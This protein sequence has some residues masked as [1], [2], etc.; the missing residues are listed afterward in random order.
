MRRSGALRL[1][2]LL[3]ALRTILPATD[4]PIHKG[5]PYFTG[6]NDELIVKDH[7]LKWFFRAGNTVAFPT[8]S[9]GLVFFSDADKVVY[10]LDAETGAPVWRLDLRTLS[11]Q[12]GSGTAVAG[13][14]KA[15]LIQGERL[16]LS[17]A[18]ILYCLDKRRGG[19]LW[20]RAGLQEGDAKRFVV[21]GIYA[22][23]LLEGQRLIYGT[24]KN[25]MAR[26]PQNGHLAWSNGDPATFGGFP[27]FYDGLVITQSRDFAK[28]RYSLVCLNATNGRTLWE[29][30]LENP[31]QILYP[32]VWKDRVYLPGGTNLT[33]LSARRG[34]VL[35]KKA[36]ADPITS[37]P[38]FTDRLVLFSLGNRRVVAVNPDN[39]A[40]EREVDTGRVSAPT[41]VLVRD[42]IYLACLTE[43]TVDGR[44]LPFAEI[45]AYRFDDPKTAL[46]EYSPP[47]PGAPTQPAA[48]GAT[49][50]VPAGAYLYALGTPTTRGAADPGP[51][52]QRPAGA[53]SSNEARPIPASNR[54]PDPAP[55][56]MPDPDWK[57]DAPPVALDLAKPGDTIRVENI[58]FEFNE[59]YLKKKSIAIL[60]GILAQ[61]RRFPGIRMEIRGH[62]DATG[63]RAYNQNLSR[64]RADA[65]MD[66]LVKNGVGPSRLRAVGFGQDQ[67]I[68]PN[69]TE[70]GRAQNR[71]TEFFILDR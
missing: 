38:G 46:W 23:P 71:R 18:T 47:F 12:L 6:N 44:V 64:R 27:A 67:P 35:W 42:Q 40:I 28:N 68:A 2:T 50:F 22:D 24:R 9:D 20:A 65:V 70:A 39:G 43:K 61:L 17:D 1:T 53:P 10:C 62:T 21:D 49:L 66:Y 14:P 34:E 31:P 32:A 7:E 63:D 25:F 33:C 52:A 30:A 5:N 45:K 60:D 59:A 36:Y 54:L 26:D 58:L 16:F 11:S 3:L 29:T 19:V 56:P 8:P 41:Y 4:W 37:G 69:D 15:P 57:P 55:R 51:I 13:K 48:A